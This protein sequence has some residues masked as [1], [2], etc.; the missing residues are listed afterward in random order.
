M[1]LFSY[2]GKGLTAVYWFVYYGQEVMAFLTM[3]TLYTLYTAS[4][5]DRRDIYKYA[6]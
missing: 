5:I 2:M 6:L 1:S 4:Y 3:Y